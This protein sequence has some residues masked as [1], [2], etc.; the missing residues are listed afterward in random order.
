MIQYLGGFLALAITFGLESVN[1]LALAKMSI[2]F[3]LKSVNLKLLLVLTS[4]NSASSLIVIFILKLV[5]GIS[6]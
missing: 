6:N 3:F 2:V 1:G 5:T 4:G